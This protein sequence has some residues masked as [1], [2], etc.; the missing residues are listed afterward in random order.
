MASLN[1]SRP[2]IQK[3]VLLTPYFYGVVTPDLSTAKLV[4]EKVYDTQYLGKA[5]YRLYEITS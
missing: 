1:I 5:K 4:D 2:I 3:N